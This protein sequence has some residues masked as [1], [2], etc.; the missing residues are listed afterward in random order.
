MQINQEK[1]SQSQKEV[2]SARGEIMLTVQQNSNRKQ[3]EIPGKV[4]VELLEGETL[5]IKVSLKKTA[6]NT[7]IL[8]KA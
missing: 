7:I 5:K 3:I 8:Q 2:K 1:L 6:M 4:S